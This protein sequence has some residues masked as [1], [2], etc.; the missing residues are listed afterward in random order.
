MLRD[1]LDHDGS[2][3]IDSRELAAFLAGWFTAQPSN[4]DELSLAFRSLDSDGDG[5]ISA[6]DLTRALCQGD[7]P[8]GPEEVE[9]LMRLTDLDQSG[10][11]EWEEFM[12]AIRL[13]T[14]ARDEGEYLARET[15]VG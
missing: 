9:W 1:R 7:D 13:R 3:R 12:S 11:I 15:R 2:G 8:L 4:E 10:A 6:E 5:R 14:D